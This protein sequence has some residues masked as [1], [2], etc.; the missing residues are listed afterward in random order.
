MNLAIF[1]ATGGTGKELVQ[2]ALEAGHRVTALVRNPA[3]LGLQHERLTVVQGDIADASC[4]ERTMAGQDAVLSA[5]GPTRNSP[6]NAM[7]IGSAN[8]VAAMK[9]H[10]VRRLIWQTG[11]GVRAAGD[12]PST[13]RT[14]MVMLMK[15]ISPS[16]LQDSEQAFRIITASGLDWTVVRVPRLK[17][18]AIEGGIRA[19]SIP[20]APTPITRADVAEFMLKQLNDKTWVGKA[21]MIGK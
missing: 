10:N 7:T 2:Q 9:K 12:A 13:I 6:K 19:S 16:V 11:A 1:G 4:V 3:K 21:P 17:D 15:I 8:V 18:G 14:V 5:L 20:P